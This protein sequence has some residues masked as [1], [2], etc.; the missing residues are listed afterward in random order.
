[1]HRNKILSRYSFIIS[2][3]DVGEKQSKRICDFGKFIIYSPITL[4]IFQ[5]FV[6]VC[7]MILP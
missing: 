7:S 3:T 4:G 6:N 1:M 2:E 5:Y